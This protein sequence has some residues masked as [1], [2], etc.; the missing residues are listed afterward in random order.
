[1][2]NKQTMALRHS[3]TFVNASAANLDTAVNAQV[4]TLGGNTIGATDV[5]GAFIGTQTVL[6]ETTTVSP[7]QAYLDATPT[8]NFTAT[9]FWTEVTQLT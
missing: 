2:A 3:K 5:L 9:V 4:N 7:T 6:P 8:L 1:M